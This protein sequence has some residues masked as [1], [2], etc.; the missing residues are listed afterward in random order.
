MLLI[1]TIVARMKSSCRPRG[2]FAGRGGQAGALCGSPWTCPL[3]QHQVAS[4]HCRMLGT[5]W[6]HCPLQDAPRRRGGCGSGCD[7]DPGVETL[8]R[9]PAD[10]E[11]QSSRPAGRW[12][13]IF[14]SCCPGAGT[15]AP[16]PSSGLGFHGRHRDVALAHSRVSVQGRLGTR[17]KFTGPQEVWPMWLASDSSPGRPGHP[18]RGT[19]ALHSRGHS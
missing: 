2:R 4:A 15:Q 18:W 8:H 16:V 12:L 9:S 5:Q 10:H 1:K 19:W 17:G 14:L 7:L 13:F 3:E 6:P 11:H